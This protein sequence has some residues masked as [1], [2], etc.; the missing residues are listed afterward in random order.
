MGVR[1]FRRGSFALARCHH[2][3]VVARA[4]SSTP[5]RGRAKLHKLH[6]RRWRADGAQATPRFRRRVCSLREHQL[7]PSERLARQIAL[8]TDGIASPTCS[9]LSLRVTVPG[10]EARSSA[11]ALRLA[12]AAPAAAIVGR[13]A[14][15]ARAA[16]AA[17][18]GWRARSRL[19]RARPP[20]LAQQGG[21]AAAARAAPSRSSTFRNIAVGPVARDRMCV[22]SSWS[23][24]R[25]DLLGVCEDLAAHGLSFHQLTR[26]DQTAPGL[27]LSLVG[28][29]LAG[30]VLARVKHWSVFQAA[31]SLFIL[32]PIVRLPSASA[33]RGR[34]VTRTLA[35]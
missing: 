3:H 31:P 29:V 19:P 6:R 1:D 2:G 10:H 7:K 28:S 4:T 13:T 8:S 30:E 26:A 16:A 20:A 25:C 11:W 32:I 18:V 12:L 5:T 34:V 33:K 14:R 27:C 15:I 17:P 9:R 22:G 24:S 35:W 21:C 23:T